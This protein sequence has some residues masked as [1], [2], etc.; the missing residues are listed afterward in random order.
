[1]KETEYK[2]DSLQEKKNERKI[3]K[4]SDKEKSQI[5]NIKRQKKEKR[6]KERK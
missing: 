4:H 5:E 1:M 2:K 3:I 6:K